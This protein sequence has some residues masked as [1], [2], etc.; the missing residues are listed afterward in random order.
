MEKLPVPD[1]ECPVGF[2]IDELCN[3]GLPVDGGVHHGVCQ[4]EVIKHLQGARL[5][6]TPG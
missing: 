5:K 3:D 4:G 6:H 1:P 2:P